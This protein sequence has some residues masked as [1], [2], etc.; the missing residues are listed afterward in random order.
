MLHAAA[1]AVGLDEVSTS[2]PEPDTTQSLRRGTRLHPATRCR[3][4]PPP[5]RDAAA[6]IGG[7]E[8]VPVLS[9]ATHRET[10][11]QLTPLSARGRAASSCVLR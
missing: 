9:V 7:G 4:E 2:P 8:D 5:M 10:L 1:P 3:C 6:R 11:A